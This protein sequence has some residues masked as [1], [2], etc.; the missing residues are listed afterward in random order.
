MK[1]MVVDDNAIVRAGLRAVLDRVEAVTEVVEAADAFAALEVAASA[2]PDICLLDVRMPGRSG[3]D[4]LPEL[5]ERMIVIMLTSMTE[6]ELIRRSLAAGARGYLVHGQLGVNEVAGAIET[7]AR[8]GLV[9]GREAAEIVLNP[10][11]TGEANPLRSLVTDREAEMLELAADG[12]SNKEISARLYLSERTVKNYLN[13]AYPKIGVH[14]RAEAV[15][16]WLKA[17][18]GR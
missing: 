8:G 14:T 10:T 15:A 12:C 16:A 6:S 13:A 17:R 11:G 7:C 9:L 1:I 2:Q 4:V 5:A 3:L 18:Q